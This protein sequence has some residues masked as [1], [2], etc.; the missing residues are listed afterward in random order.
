MEI[1]HIIPEALG[2]KTIESNLWLACTL[3]NKYKAARVRVRDPL[4]GATVALFNPRYE[5]WNDHFRWVANGTRILGITR[6]GRATVVALNLN[7][8]FLV[9]SRELWVRAGWHPPQD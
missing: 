1:D 4:T 5:H 6:T 7:R 9:K 2:G 8:P 3:C